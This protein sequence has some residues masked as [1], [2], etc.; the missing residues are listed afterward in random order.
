MESRVLLPFEQ[1]P[2]SVMYRY[3]AFPLGVIQGNAE[4]DITPWLC[5]KFLNCVF[6]PI[7]QNHFSI[8]L[9]DHWGVGEEIHYYQQVQLFFND[10][11]KIGVDIIQLLIDMLAHGSYVC[12]DWNEEYIPGKQAYKVGYFLHDYLLIGFDNEKKVF[13]AADSFTDRFSVTEIPY[14]NMRQSLKTLAD[15]KPVLLFYRFNSE[16]DFSFHVLK[17]IGALEDY[18]SS[19]NS[20][21]QYTKGAIYGLEAIDALGKHY[22]SLRPQNSFDHRYSRGLMEHKHIMLERISYLYQ[23]SYIADRRYI[24]CA[25]EVYELSCVLHNM[26]IRFKMLGDGHILKEIG[27]IIQKIKSIELSYLPFVKAELVQLL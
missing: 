12:G 1:K 18:L 27:A 3:I 15:G 22:A 14:G 13:Y 24:A 26:G 21:P 10:Y 17:T 19:T 8:S 7:S 20:L 25:K 4:R 11:E 23:N 6:Y 16:A 5:H 2:L 9:S